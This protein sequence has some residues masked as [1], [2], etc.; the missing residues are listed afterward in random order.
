MASK[1]IPFITPCTNKVFS[2]DVVLPPAYSSQSY[3]EAELL[4]SVTPEIQFL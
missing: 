3:L 4:E 1:T 2:S